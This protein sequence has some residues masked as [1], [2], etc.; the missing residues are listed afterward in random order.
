M[1]QNGIQEGLRVC[2]RRGER[3]LYSSL[4]ISNLIQSAIISPMLPAHGVI[5]ARRHLTHIRHA[6]P[7]CFRFFC[8]FWGDIHQRY[9]YSP[10]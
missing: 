5:L 1:Q 3:Y 8:F 10:M 6:R 7:Y 2:R 9:P 4:W